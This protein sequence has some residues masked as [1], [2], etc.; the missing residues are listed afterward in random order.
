[1]TIQLKKL[2]IS[3]GVL[4]TNNTKDKHF[5]GENGSLEYNSLD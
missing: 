4:D 2:G 1:M 3:H 5:R